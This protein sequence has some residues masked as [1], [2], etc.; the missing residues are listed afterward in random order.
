MNNPS[1]EDIQEL[2]LNKAKLFMKELYLE[3]FSKFLYEYSENISD[4]PPKA[5]LLNITCPTKDNICTSYWQILTKLIFFVKEKNQYKLNPLSF[6]YIQYISYQKYKKLNIISI[7][8]H[9][10]IN[11]LISVYIDLCKSQIELN[12]ETKRKIELQKEK[13]RQLRRRSSA[14]VMNEIKILKKS[15]SLTNKKRIEIHKS[16][17]TQQI[18]YSQSLAKLFI[19][20]TDKNSIQERHSNNMVIKRFQK[21]NLNSK[22]ETNNIILEKIYSRILN[23]NKQ[24]Y[25]EDNKKKVLRRFQNHY[26][27]MNK[28]KK[29]LELNKKY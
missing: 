2:I 27:I 23:E 10:N 29:S 26:N 6:R 8:K 19:G 25:I 17:N 15:Q 7:S 5:P 28:Y 18:V 21:L 22:K 16:Q 1:K 3:I 20:E 14:L 24:L 12:K 11:T 9:I 13:L 4:F